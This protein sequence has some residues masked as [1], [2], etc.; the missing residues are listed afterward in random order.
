[1]ST[2]LK[3]LKKLAETL[4]EKV[5]Y[6]TI[7]YDELT[8]EFEIDFHY[9]QS[10]TYSADAFLDFATECIS[11]QVIPEAGLITTN[12]RFFQLIIATDIS[13]N[14]F[15]Y[16]E[17][18]I[19][20][21]DDEGN[22]VSLRFNNP[23]V[24]YAALLCKSFHKVQ[25]NFTA[26]VEVC[27]VASA[28]D[29][30]DAEKRV[31]TFL[32]ELDVTYNCAFART[33]FFYVYDDGF[34]FPNFDDS[35]DYTLNSIEEYN[36][37]IK[38]FIEAR[39]AP[40][41]ELE[42][43]GLYRVFEFFAPIVSRLELYKQLEQKLKDPK[44]FNPDR[45]YLESIVELIQNA[46]NEDRDREQIKLVFVTTVNILHIVGLTP[47]SIRPANWPHKIDNTTTKLVLDDLN[48]AIADSLVS[49]RN[50]IAHAK[51][52]YV[53]KSNECPNQDILQFNIFLKKAAAQVIRWYNQ[54][55]A[56]EKV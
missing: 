8:Q 48:K 4:E 17:K 34:D 47:Q 5:D 38:L 29:R 19:N 50:R 16:L 21:V 22:V 32:F 30:V 54:L 15:G 33:E 45:Q 36:E 18:E 41:P 26:A 25:P 10:F 51:S 20:N 52:N 37:G 24:G 2:K 6:L 43:F 7:E 13:T 55:P 28:F 42:L 9:S 11:M 56:Y 39:E 40:T 14:P 3:K 53:P 44:V 46:K 27:Y 1:M 12:R 49:T 31:A 23:F 35:Q